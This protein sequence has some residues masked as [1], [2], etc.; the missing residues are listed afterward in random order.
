[1]KNIIRELIGLT[2]FILVNVYSVFAQN[3]VVWKQVDLSQARNMMSS[4]STEPSNFKVFELDLSALNEGLL[5]APMRSAFRERAEKIMTFPNHEGQLEKF[6]VMEASIMHPD[7]AAKYKNIKSYAGQ[8][9]DDPSATIRFSVSDQLGFHGM[10]TSGKHTTSFIDPFSADQ[11]NYMVYAGPESS[12]GERNLN[13][14]TRHDSEQDL[15]LRRNFSFERTND[16]KLR[17]YRLALSSTAEYGNIFAGSGTDA[18]K[19]ANILAQMVVTMTRVNGIFERDLAITLEL[20]ADNDKIIFFGDTTSDPWNGEFNAKTQEVNDDVIGD[21]NYDIGH[22]F[23]TTGGGNAGCLSCVC[24][25]GQK[26]SGYTGRRDPTGDPFDVDYVAHEMAHQFGG[27]HTMNFCKRSG[28]ESSE[29]EPG[30]GSSIM[31]Y[32][33]ICSPNIQSNSDD[34][35]AYVNIRD[36]S[37]NI[38]NGPSASC[39]QIVDISNNP[40]TANAGP[41]YTI[42]KSTAFVLRGEGSDPDGGDT[43]TY[44][45]EQND[46]EEAPR[47]GFPQ[48]TWT[49]GPLFR[50]LKG[51]VSAN[52][53]MPKITDVIA[54]NLTPI[55][56]VVPS[57]GRTMEFSLTVRDNS[58]GGGQTSD[59]LMTVTVDGNSG[60]FVVTAPNNN[61]TWRA[62]EN[63]MVTWN[64]AGTDVSP[65]NATNVNILLST[66]GGMT[67]PIPLVSNTPNDGSETITVPN[68]V[69]STSRIK[70]EAAD[71]IFYDISNSNFTIDSSSIDEIPPTAPANLTATNITSS[72]AELSWTA[73]TDNI[74]VTGYEIFVNGSSHSSNS[75]TTF[76]LSGLTSGTSYAVSVKA[77]DA[78][79]NE[80]EEGQINVTTKQVGCEGGINSFPFSE[81]WESGLGVWTQNE[82]DNLDWILNTNG[83][84][85]NNTGPSSAIE[86][87]HYLY[88]EASDEGAGFPNKIAILTSPCID[89][90]TVSVAKFNFAYHMEGSSMGELIVGASTDG[91][92]WTNL[93]SKSGSQGVSWHEA[94]VDLTAFAGNKVILRFV[95]TTGNSFTSDMAIDKLNISTEDSGGEC[96]E[97]TLNLILDR[98]PTETTWTLSSDSGTTIISGGPYDVPSDNITVVNCLKLGSYKFTINDSGGDGI[99]C[100]FGSGSYNFTDASGNTLASGDSFRNSEV[101]NFSTGNE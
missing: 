83:T 62:G 44:T 69:S 24:L 75:D 9:I 86:G 80:S 94:N 64:V 31:G 37:A 34:Y 73:S 76:V 67:F 70:V 63:Q 1:M 45:W 53:F 65:V 40:P 10:I 92:S 25:S 2:V 33:G 66:D 52:R 101:K 32:A 51:T 96:T 46:P 81:G 54:G 55:W 21:S 26:G 78:A 93:W 90:T 47:G 88:I 39:A 5:N 13:C 23:N 74:G 72:S 7:L 99:C 48:D 97:V 68:N 20:I 60:P 84:Q 85:S 8:G 22:N 29:V 89:L 77:K 17:K 38:Q 11:K 15:E 58:A 59:D 6:K 35:F 19:K 79:G 100:A 71:N 49:K 98:F 95:G 57:V 27:Y 16:K 50:S 42:P 61:V 43:L 36:I 30:S 82:S 91:N 41:D 56:E 28:N 18:Q 3:Q 14:L 4:M 12:S 87:S